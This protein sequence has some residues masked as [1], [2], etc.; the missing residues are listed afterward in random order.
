M[1]E[2]FTLETGEQKKSPEE[3]RFDELV[4][5]AQ[6]KSLEGNYAFAETKE[7]ETLVHRESLRGAYWESGDP[8]KMAMFVLQ[9]AKLN[10]DGLAGILRILERQDEGQ[11]KTSIMDQAKDQTEKWKE[12][13]EEAKN[14]L[15]VSLSPVLSEIGIAVPQTRNEAT[16]LRGKIISLENLKKLEEKYKTKQ[17]DKE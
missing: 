11:G 15:V 16:A 10:L 4:R 17:E 13:T 12:E 8:E 7:E 6:G 1:L 9:E 5:G 14:K 2:K 3:I